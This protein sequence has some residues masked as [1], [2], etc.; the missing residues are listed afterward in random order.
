MVSNALRA[1]TIVK[2][3]VLSRNQQ[4]VRMDFEQPLDDYADEM[5]LQCVS[6]LVAEHD[7]VLLSDWPKGTF[8]IEAL[9]EVCRERDIPCLVDPK[10]TNFSRYRGATMITPN[11][12][13][14]EAVAGAQSVDEK[15]SNATKEDITDYGFD[16]VLVTR[17]ER[18]MTLHRD[19]DLFIY[20]HSPKRCLT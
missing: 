16:A 18:G 15:I 11:L 12:S 1:E 3:R 14:F 19:G 2:L 6:N 10:G 9:I 7:I 13:E 8:L 17:S 4:L 5:F 20:P